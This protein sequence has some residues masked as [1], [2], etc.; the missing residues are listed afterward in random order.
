MDGKDCFCD[1]REYVA[2]EF[3]K[4]DGEG[5]GIK[6]LCPG[7]EANCDLKRAGLLLWLSFG[8]GTRSFTHKGES[9]HSSKLSPGVVGGSIVTSISCLSMFFQDSGHG[10]IAIESSLFLVHRALLNIDGQQ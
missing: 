9:S 8:R 5:E 2:A 1:S 6:K 7:E 10:K 3:F 4:G